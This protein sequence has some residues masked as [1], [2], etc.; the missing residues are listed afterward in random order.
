MDTPRYPFL[1]L[2]VVNEPYMEALR[3]AAARVVTSGRYVGGAECAAFEAELAAATGTG[4]AVGV[5]NGLDAL[6]L[7]LRAYIEMGEMCPGDE[8]IVPANTYVA[9]V[10]AVSDAGLK[11]VPVDADIETLNMDMSL[12]RGAITSRTRAIMTVHLYGRV[13]WSEELERVAAEFGL[14]V[15]EDNAQAIGAEWR[16]RMAGAL[17]DA[18]AFSFYPTKNVGALGDAGAVTTSDERLAATVRALANYGSDRRYHN[19]Y[20][21]FN[22]RLDPIQAAFL[23]AKLPFTAEENERRRQLAG[24]YLENVA[25]TPSLR[26]PLLPEDPHEHVFHQFVV[27]AENRGSFEEHLRANGVGYDIHYATPPHMQPCYSEDFRGLRFPVTEL[28]ASR[29][30]S[31]PITR[32][33]TP[34]DAAAIAAILASYKG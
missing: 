28:I 8:V 19:L 5:S 33:T 18:A 25:S 11:P 12:L 27:L 17:G 14:K 34:S 13:A 9:S 30:V 29:C 7:I 10:L 31:L 15:I 6:R 1:D 2:A 24:I 26:M 32:T 3:D 16:G 22:C 20:K 23:R 4:F 21:G